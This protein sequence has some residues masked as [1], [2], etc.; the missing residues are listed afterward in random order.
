[1]IRTLK[2]IHTKTDYATA[3][4]RAAEL[5]L[6]SPA[7]GSAAGDELDILATL[8]ATYDR[9]HFPLG[10]ADPIAAIR[11]AM[12]QR[13]MEAKDL[14]PYLGTRSRVSEVLSGKRRLSIE[15]MSRLHHGL[16]IPLECLMP[17]TTPVLRPSRRSVSAARRVATRR[18]SYQA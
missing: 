1:M 16:G 5:V 10:P 15:Q 11:F 6:A 14:V 7:K 9:E 3:Q 17:T 8:I 2:P 12:D 4:A 13:D 18:Q